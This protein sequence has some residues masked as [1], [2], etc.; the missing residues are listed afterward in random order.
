MATQRPQTSRRDRDELRNQLLAWLAERVEDARLSELE[1]PFSAGMSSETLLF[2]ID[3]LDGD[4]RVARR[5]VARMPPEPGDFPVFPTYD[6]AMQHDV[7]RLVRERTTAPVP[8]ILWL[9]TDARW[10]GAPFFVMERVDGAVPPD[11]LPYTFGD[12]WFHDADERDRDTVIGSSVDVLAAI[13]GIDA[14]DPQL[15]AALRAAGDP[16]RAH[17]DAQREYYRWVVGDGPRSALAESMFEW[18]EDHWPQAAPAVLSWGDARLG[19][20]LYDDFKA[21]AVLDWEM[22]GV[23]PRELDLGWMIY[24][25][26][27]FQDIAE[28]YGMVGLPDVM[29]RDPTVQAY[30]ARTGYEPR[31]ID[32]YIAYAAL[33]HYVIMLRIH[34]RAAHFGETTLAE[35][36]DA[37]VIH[38]PTL[39]AMLDGSYWDRLAG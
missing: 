5:C 39:R 3:Y 23:G 12:N 14:D 18:L 25:H 36:P 26:R 11:M 30:A 22:A 38:A 19:N 34:H 37:V 17:L 7:M 10:L 24:M 16:L 1:T 8:A 33:R 35:D 32:W 9:E 31:D 13:H 20:I 4:E 6:I 27:F 15:P 29:R 21:R 28:S 2:E